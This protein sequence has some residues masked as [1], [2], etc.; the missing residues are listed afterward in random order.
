MSTDRALNG[1]VALVT[2]GA[3]LIGAAVVEA[4]VQAGAD[5]ILADIDRDNGMRVAARAGARF[6]A[7]D[8]SADDEIEDVVDVV[9]AQFGRLDILVNLAAAYIDRGV[10][11]TRADWLAT[12][13]VN[14]FGAA[15]LVGAAQDALV[16][17]GQGRV[18]NIVSVSGRIAQAGRWVYPASKAALEQLTRS[19]A[20]D[21]A[22]QGIRVN[23]LSLGWT[24][25]GPVAGLS[26]YDREKSDLF[27]GKFHMR[28]CIGDPAE[29]ASAV[30]WLASPGSSLLTG[31]VVHA[32]GG[33]HGLGPEGVGFSMEALGA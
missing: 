20:L 2:G 6:Q 27:A 24:W 33:Y 4:L 11:S 28:G 29:V 19:M 31:G 25:S 30:L 5:V 21:L 32:D 16:A 12:F 18:I 14:L 8:L 22:P 13:N 10:K 23:A 17:S 15:M 3:T 9:M 7:L 26:G 1:Q